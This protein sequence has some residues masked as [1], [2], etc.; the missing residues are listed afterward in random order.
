M[1]PCPYGA[2]LAPWGKSLLC[3]ETERGRAGSGQ[4]LL[5][6]DSWGL[7][8]ERFMNRKGDSQQGILER[9]CLRL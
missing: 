1:W 5:K 3:E 4:I 2:D 7:G 8:Q 6:G 9:N